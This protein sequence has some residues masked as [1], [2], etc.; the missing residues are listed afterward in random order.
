MVKKTTIRFEDD[1]LLLA[2]RH[3]ALDEGISFQELVERAVKEYMKTAV[4][5]G[6]EANK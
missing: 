2:A 4:K 3:R 5:R 1:R 6:K